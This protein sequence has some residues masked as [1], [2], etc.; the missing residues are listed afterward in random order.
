MSGWDVV[1]LVAGVLAV[2]DIV[3]SARAR[4]LAATSIGLLL[5]VIFLL[6]AT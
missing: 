4:T 6:F 5:V 3:E 2:F 1:L